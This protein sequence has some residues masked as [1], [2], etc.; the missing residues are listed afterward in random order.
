M[1]KVTFLVMFQI[2]LEKVAIKMG[3]RFSKKLI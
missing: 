3:F 1:Q 2:F